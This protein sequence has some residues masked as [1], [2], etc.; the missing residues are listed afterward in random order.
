MYSY[1]PEINVQSLGRSFFF[2]IV[3]LFVPKNELVI[4]KRY[5]TSKLADRSGKYI[6]LI[7][8]AMGSLIKNKATE[9]N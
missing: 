1:I 4:V 9:S 7:F 5:F 2:F 3:V 6:A 8:R